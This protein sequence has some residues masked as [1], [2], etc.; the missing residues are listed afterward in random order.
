M[1]SAAFRF[2][3]WFG[4]RWRE[5]AA[6]LAAL[7]LLSNT[8][9]AQE[10]GDNTFRLTLPNGMEVVCLTDTTLPLVHVE[11][12]ILAGA[13]YE[14]RTQHGIS[15]LWEHA[16]WDL[17]ADSLPLAQ[18]RRRQMGLVTHSWV[19]A[20]ALQ[21]ACSVQ[22]DS[23]KPALAYLT[24]CLTAPFFD[25]RLVAPAKA[26][27][28][29]EVELLESNPEWFLEEDIRQNLWGKT[30]RKQPLGQ[31][32][33][34]RNLSEEDLYDY[35]AAMVN[36]RAMR[37]VVSGRVE[38]A[39]VEALLTEVGLATWAS[40]AQPKFTVRDTVRLPLPDASAWFVS[41]N[42]FADQPEIRLTWVGPDPSSDTEG[43]FSAMV[44]ATWLNHPENALRRSLE[45]GGLALRY[46]ADYAPGHGAGLFTLKVTP[47]RDSLSRCLQVLLQ[48]VVAELR[49]G[50]VR[51]EDWAV[52]CQQI[53]RE[54]RLLIATPTAWNHFISQSWGL[55]VPLP[56]YTHL[57]VEG[58]GTDAMD[59]LLTRYFGGKPMMCSVLTNSKDE[60]KFDLV[61]A[62][63]EYNRLLAQATATVVV[64][65]VDTPKAS[66]PVVVEP[67]SLIAAKAFFK[68]V[69]IRFEVNAL[70]PEGAFL[71][72]L[73]KV[74]N[75]M[76][77]NPTLKFNID[78]YTD[79]EGDGVKNYLLSVA[80]AEAVRDHLV[81][82]H[83]IDSERL[84]P[85]G[86]GEAF[87]EFNEKIRSE[88]VKN[89]RI[90]FTLQ[91]Q[92]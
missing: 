79:A 69:R 6:G 47:A 30:H 92:P 83:G 4:S 33:R 62:R 21:F 65:A 88:D 28:T 19:N 29:H 45:S 74:A 17:G 48:G 37:L 66:T 44:L 12:S 85:R 22:S 16:F 78:S 73:A 35:H 34:I 75:V 10:I 72:S 9:P 31:Y 24:R 18:L 67:P 3:L 56:E 61:A 70:L 26:R 58:L 82:V 39:Q 49:P 77:R 86:F 2:R 81:Q 20:E 46:A 59:R 50:E 43:Y 52:A 15:H 25:A 60:R 27:I 8:L 23:L 11:V 5:V 1:G 7:L 64:A 40:A 38:P 53:G 87:P 42:E 71:D 91:E 80:R 89:R 32:F 55:G 54:L 63:S 84:Q 57:T 90:A 36:P 68:E 76:R 13:L 14:Q 51:D 41:V